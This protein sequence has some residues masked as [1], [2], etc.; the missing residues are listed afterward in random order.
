M[1][2]R[3]VLA[4]GLLVFTSQA[5]AQMDEASR[6][7]LIDKLGNVQRGLAPKDPSKVAVT[8]RL[9]DLLSERARFDSMKEI[10]QGCTV[11]NAGA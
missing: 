2:Q 4:A 11:C 3:I 10:E 8:L 5:F 6:S 7:L 9:A 1:F